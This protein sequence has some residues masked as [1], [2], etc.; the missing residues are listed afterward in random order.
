KLYNEHQQDLKEVKDLLGKYSKDEKSKFFRK[1]DIKDNYFSYINGKSSQE[2]VN[3]NLSKIIEKLKIEENE[4]VKYE[5]IL[6]RISLSLAVP[7]QVTKDN[8]VLPSQ[9][10]KYE[11]VSILENMKE[12]FPFLTKVEDGY[13]V[14]KKI[15]KIFSFRI[16]YYVGPL[17]STHDK[18]W[19]VKK[20]D[21]KIYPWNFEEVVNLEESAEKFIQN[22]INKCTYLS[23]EDVIPKSSLLY[24]KFSV[25]NELNNL[26]ING[27]KISVI[28]KQKIYRDLFENEKKVTIKKLKNYLKSENCIDIEISGI[29]GYSKNSLSSYIDFKNILG[30]KIKNDSAIKM[31]EDC[32]KWIT[33]YS[34]EKKLLIKK[35]TDIYG[36][37]LTKDEIKRIASLKYKDWGR[38]SSKFLQGIQSYSL[39]TGEIKNIIQM[40][41]ET[42]ENLMELLSSK[43]TFRDEIEKENNLGETINY[44]EFSFENMLKDEYFSAPVKRMIW[45]SLLIVNEIKKITKKAPTKIFIEMA[46]QEDE[47][48]D[49]RKTT[50][51]NLYKAIKNE[52]NEWVTKER[53]WLNEIESKTDN[54]MRSKKIYLYYTQLGRCMY[55][56]EAIP[57]ANLFENN[58]YD[59]DHIF[60]RSKTKD[61]SIE[62]LVLVKRNINA[63]KEDEYPLAENIQKSRASFWKYLHSKKLIG[64]KKYDRLTRKME[65][66]DEELSGFIARQL[67]ETRQS[68]KAVADILKKMFSESKIVYVKANLTSDFRKCFN[69]LKSRDINDFHHAHDAYLNIITGNVYNIK[70]TDNPLNFIK[71]RRIENRKYNLKTEKI[72]AYNEKD[73]EFWNPDTMIKQI[74]E[75]IYNKRPQ[76]TRYSFEQHGGFFDQNILPKEKAG[77]GVGYSPIKQDGIL[78]NMAKYGGY[79]KIAGTYFFLVEHLLKGKLVRT[80]EVLPLYLAKKVKN[81]EGLTKYCEEN[82]KLINPVIKC[83]KIKYNSLFKINGFLYRITGKTADYYETLPDLQFFLEKKLYEYVRKL[84][85]YTNENRKSNELS[86]EKNIELYNEII[87]KL[88]KSIYS[89]KKS[90]ITYKKKGSNL[91]FILENEKENFM[92]LDI[93]KQN[94]V[95]IEIMKL[96]KSYKTANLEIFSLGKEVGICKI[97]KNIIDLNDIKLINQSITGLFENEID[98]KKV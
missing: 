72:F 60:P 5:R 19:I 75:F 21:T 18:A 39:E 15:E 53:D 65:F 45:Q 28:L 48:K 36:E 3:K 37:Y 80:I 23:R 42:N 20:S 95:L 69:I 54:E 47:R 41:W 74:E 40:L 70:F 84:H 11:L 85:L 52:T 17:N 4:K 35:I 29:D 71:N 62:N 12:Y 94:K 9:I 49:S 98:L 30:E 55:S 82:L 34:G 33:L 86:K 14:I 66:S 63:K 76:F 50:L 51:C 81:A 83:T 89:K 58:I 7:K 73:K 16:P 22:L 57:F 77:I 44:S 96:F 56:G 92:S 24:S 97:H 64:D 31:V 93:E 13:S 2:E 27:E 46:R 90:N 91:C 32:I 88:K 10:H 79:A 67:V 6:S 59:I 87:N 8:G 26:K 1:K 78:D 25:L 61:D 68:T 38:L 43:Y